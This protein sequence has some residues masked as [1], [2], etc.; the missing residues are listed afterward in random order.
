MAVSIEERGRM[1]L[2]TFVNP[3]HSG[4]VCSSL[5]DDTGYYPICVYNATGQ[6]IATVEKP[7]SAL[8]VP[9]GVYFL[10]SKKK[11]VC[12]KIVLVK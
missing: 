4:V 7:Q 9:S 11:G 10:A 8:H 12:F 2:P 6:V 5:I 3:A 1:T